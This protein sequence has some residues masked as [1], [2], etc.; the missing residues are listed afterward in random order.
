MA[1]SRGSGHGQRDLATDASAP[2]KI[3][4]LGEGRVGK[5]SLLRRYVSRTFDDREAST[6]SAAYLERSLNLKGR[7]VNL[8]LWD[9][10]GQERFH[11]LAPIYYRDALGA[12]LVYDVTD[13]ESF[14]RVAKWVEELQS[15][16]NNCALAV[17]GN[18]ADLRQQVRVSPADAEA[19]AKSIGAWHG[20]TSAKVGLGVEEAF[21]RLAEEA[22]ERRAAG[23]SAAASGFG[24]HAFSSRASQRGALLIA[25]D[26]LR[27]QRESSRS[28]VRG[29]CCAGGGAR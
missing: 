18:K 20:L 11:S 29:Q 12:L 17:V 8:S 15:Q 22:L 26:A 9:T 16:G 1:R 7:Q 23:S 6:Q 2:L 3:V 13:V 27:P 25:D 4:I 28:C 21:A 14:R 24:S 10:A 5:T 19:Y